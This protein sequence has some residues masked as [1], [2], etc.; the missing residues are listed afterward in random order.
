MKEIWKDIPGYEGHYLASN[1]GNIK[2]LKHGKEKLINPFYNEKGYLI[3]FLSKNNNQKKFKVHQL[4]A[5]SF[6]NHKPCGMESI[7]DHI[8]NDRTD[9]KLENLRIV[10]NRDNCHR[11]KHGLNTSKYKGVYRQ[12]NKWRAQASIKNKKFHIGYYDDEEEASKAYQ[13]F[14]ITLT[15]SRI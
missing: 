4:V 2:S 12:N 11:V 9:N 5:M 8:N 14:I 1:L 10:S 6:L 3:C 15:L 13:E 7:I